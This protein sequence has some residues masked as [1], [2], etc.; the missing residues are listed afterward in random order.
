[1][2]V[3]ALTL[4]QWPFPTPPHQ[5]TIS[6]VV[7]LGHVRE[8]INNPEPT[9]TLESDELKKFTLPVVPRA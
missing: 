8:R 1:M 2:Y 9:E 5:T 4:N 6:Q 3:M 7:I